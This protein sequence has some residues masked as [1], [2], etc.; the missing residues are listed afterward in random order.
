MAKGGQKDMTGQQYF[1]Y[2]ITP[3][4]YQDLISTLQRIQHGGPTDELGQQAARQLVRLTELGLQAYYE[5]PASLIAMPSVVRKAANS[6]ISA[7]FK[8]VNMVIHSVLTK[9]SLE[10]LQ[11]MATEMSHLIGISNTTEP[12]Y[13]ICFPLPIELSKRA[14]QLLA[15]VQQDQNVD[16]YRH[17]IIASL[18]ELIE[19]AIGV[20]YTNPLS[21]V[22]VGK[23]TR[24]A[25]DMGMSTVKKGSNMVLHKVFKTMPHSQL[26]PLADYFKTLLHQGV[27]PHT[28]PTSTF[29]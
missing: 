28:K 4:V 5:R 14:S 12:R 25:A 16:E 13:F 24:A 19:E 17:D 7:I 15:R 20:F 29:A 10:E 11:S 9:R 27:Q 21:R 23:I 1:G 2:E 26:L 8:A 6:G 18:E 22:Q 3:D